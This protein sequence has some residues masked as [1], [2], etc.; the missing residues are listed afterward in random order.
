MACL[1]ALKLHFFWLT[2]RS[3]VSAPDK[4]LI[5]SWSEPPPSHACL[6]CIVAV[7]MNRWPARL[8]WGGEVINQSHQKAICF[9]V[10]ILRGQTLSV[11]PQPWMFWAECVMNDQKCRG[12]KWG[13][14]ML[15]VR[16]GATPPWSLKLLKHSI[17]FHFNSLRLSVLHQKPKSTRYTSI[18]LYYVGICSKTMLQ[19]KHYP[20]IGP[21]F[22]ANQCLCQT[23]LWPK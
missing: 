4:W 20:L 16:I 7:V 23:L 2:M 3:T 5:S 18:R 12:E 15:N 1:C 21:H 22:R 10:H 6:L 11:P 17:D 14:T 9:T 8:D 13:N 19:C